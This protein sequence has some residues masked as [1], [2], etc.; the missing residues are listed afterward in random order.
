[1]QDDTKILKRLRKAIKELR[2]IETEARFVC[3][4]TH[5]NQ[6]EWKEADFVLR[7]SINATRSIHNTKESNKRL[8]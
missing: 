8:R 6:R 5:T 7:A 3:M 2:A 1:M 4:N